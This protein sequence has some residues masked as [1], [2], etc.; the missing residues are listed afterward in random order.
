[1][2]NKHTPT[3][4][5]VSKLDKVSINA[6]CGSDGLIPVMIPPLADDFIGH[7]SRFEN[8]FEANA[9]FIVKACNAHDELVKALSEA[10]QYLHDMLYAGVLEND[11][12]H[13]LHIINTTIA[14]ALAKA[15]G[16]A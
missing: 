14:Q 5:Y 10:Q 15:K 8:Q 7:P 16:E 13:N 2:E 3:P 12:S 1:M 9:A 6:D 4:W 11:G